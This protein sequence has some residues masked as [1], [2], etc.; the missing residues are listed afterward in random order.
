MHRFTLDQTRISSL[1]F[2]YTSL[3]SY[4]TL[5]TFKLF[6]F[7]NFTIAFAQCCSL[8]C[9]PQYKKIYPLLILPAPLSS[10]KT[11]HYTQKML[12]GLRQYLQSACVTQFLLFFSIQTFLNVLVQ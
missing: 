4:N 11:L 8:M 10:K 7:N 12:S 2:G 6:F 3:F 1:L 5:L 9:F